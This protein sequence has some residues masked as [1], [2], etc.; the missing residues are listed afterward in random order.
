VKPPL[1]SYD[2]LPV[3]GNGLHSGWHVFGPDDSVGLINLQ[4]PETVLAAA[5]LVRRGAAFALGAPTTEMDP[6]ITLNRTPPRQRVFVNPATGGLDD[7]IDNYFPQGSSQW[8]ALAHVAADGA[9][10]AYYNG[11]TRDEILRGER[12]TIDHWA[13]RG[14]IGRGVLVDIA[15]DREASGRPWDPGASEAIET[16]EIAAALEK[17]GTALVSGDLLFVRTGFLAWCRSRSRR[18]REAMRRDL[19][20]PGLA[21]TEDMAAFLWDAHV[22]AVVSDTFAVE[23]W[24]GVAGPTESANVPSLHRI[25]IGQFGMALGELWWLDDLAADC[26]ADGVYEFFVVSAPINQPGGIGSPANA[27]AIK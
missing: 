1:P 25:L 20:A 5:R 22:S 19:H 21:P 9:G 3:D 4:T 16:A 2:E 7:V 11:A 24:P 13:R 10:A 6:P 8:D 12:N 27:L 15:R 18:E 14:I 23:V 26:A 17:N